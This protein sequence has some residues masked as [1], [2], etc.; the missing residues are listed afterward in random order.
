[1]RTSVSRLFVYFSLFSY[2]CC[3][4]C[5]RDNKNSVCR[6]H[7]TGYQAALANVEAAVR[8]EYIEF[9]LRYKFSLIPPRSFHS[10]VS[11]IVGRYNAS[12]WLLNKKL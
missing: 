7:G 9:D 8:Q 2:N 4:S 6:V 12:V 1:M 5:C 3:A 10:F 11:G